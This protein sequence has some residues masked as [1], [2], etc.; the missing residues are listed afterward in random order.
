MTVDI[1]CFE[2]SGHEAT[3]YCAE[4]EADFCQRSVCEKISAEF[5]AKKQEALDK[6]ETFAKD[7]LETRTSLDSFLKLNLEENENLKKDLESR[8]KLKNNLLNVD[9]IKISAKERCA[10]INFLEESDLGMNSYK[11]AL[12]DRMKL[13]ISKFELDSNDKEFLKF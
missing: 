9:E 3:F 1:P 7:S 8:L 11:F 6:L 5:D 12:T 4:C 2:N 13:K 10:D